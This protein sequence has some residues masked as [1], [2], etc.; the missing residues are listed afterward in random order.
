MRRILRFFDDD[1]LSARSFS[2]PL[3]LGVELTFATDRCHSLDDPWRDA[4]VAV[5]FHEEDASVAAVL[6]AAAERPVDGVIAVGDRPVVLAA[7]VA[8]ALGVPW[9]PADAARASAH[10]RLARERLARAGLPTP[11]CLAAT[12]DDD[13]IDVSRRARYPAVVKPVSLSGSRGVIRVDTPE[14]LVAAFGRVSIAAVATGDSRAAH[15]QRAR[16]PGRGLHRRPRVRRRRADVARRVLESRHLRQA[17]SARRSVLRGDDLRDAVTRR[18]RRAAGD[19]RGGRCGRDRTRAGARADPRGVPRHAVGRGRT[20]AGARAGGGGTSDRRFVLASVA[21]HVGTA[22][23]PCRSSTCCSVTLSANA[24]CQSV[25]T[26]R[27][28]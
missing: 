18:C 12:V 16:N 1:R 8:E 19:R 28:R 6:A 22:V 2:E 24:R 3:D 23:R 11:R 21:I 9:H 13:P 4:A 7:R 27:R 17:R 20:G 14:A 25:K 15:R 5:R 26:R 10:K